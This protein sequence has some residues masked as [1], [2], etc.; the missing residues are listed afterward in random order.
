[1]SVVQVRTDRPMP[2]IARACVDA[3]LAGHDVQMPA[4]TWRRPGLTKAIAAEQRA[5]GMGTGRWEFTTPT[6]VDTPDGAG[7]PDAGDILGWGGG[8]EPLPDSRRARRAPAPVAAPAP[9]RTVPEPVT[10]PAGAG[11]P[12]GPPA[13]SRPV[14]PHPGPVRQ[15]PVHVNQP[16]VHAPVVPTPPPVAPPVAVVQVG[17]PLSQPAA[18]MH[19]AYAL[20]A[21]SQPVMAGGLK[22]G[23]NRQRTFGAPVEGRRWSAAQALAELADLDGL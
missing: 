15:R 8:S 9:V 7:L 14:Q 23:P 19:A 5:R 16:V 4:A 17:Q 18:M 11:A 21:F 10:V 6:G 12:S 20:M 1:M 2:D 13:P 22:P 3:L